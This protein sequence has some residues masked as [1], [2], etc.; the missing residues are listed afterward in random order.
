MDREFHI[1]PE[2]KMSISQ[3]IRTIV[4]GTARRRRP[5]ETISQIRNVK[6]FYLCFVRALCTHCGINN[7]VGTT[8]PGRTRCFQRASI[9]QTLHALL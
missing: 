6:R 3:P 5:Y 2:N 9:N 7:V 8:G 4:L 1:F